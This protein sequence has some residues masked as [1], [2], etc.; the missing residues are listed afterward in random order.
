M[1]V[2]HI[3]SYNRLTMTFERHHRYLQCAFYNKDLGAPH[4]TLVND[5]K[6]FRIKQRRRKK[7]SRYEGVLVC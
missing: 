7:G 5:W 2:S 4:E 3:L 1:T 6:F